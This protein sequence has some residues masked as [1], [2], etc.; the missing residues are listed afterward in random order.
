MDK[1]AIATELLDAL[2]RGAL[3]QPITARDPGFGAE[4]AY[5]VAAEV[6]RRRRSRGEKPVGRKIGFTN[7]TI[8]P[9]YGITMP[10][11]AHVYDS[12]VTFLEGNSGSLAIGRLAQPRIEPEIV[13][14]F[15]TSPGSTR[16]VAQLLSCIDWIAHG[17]E[18][19]QSHFPDWKFKTADTIAA[20]GLHG[21]LVV[22]PKQPVSGLVDLATKLRSFTITVARDGMV[23]ARGG[24]ANV[25]DSPLLAATHFLSVLKDQPQFEP[26]R[27]GEI[28]T[29]GTL[30]APLP[31][32]PG[33]N[34]STDLSGIELEGL[35]LQFR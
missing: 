35:K 20:F 19:V 28:V 11:W 18:V 3:I 31:V 13:L 10:I 27:P 15:K 16:D 1:E 5:D 32:R 34:W 8:W 4:A 25:L 22:G 29:T 7:R 2:D 24:G 26:I 21:A 9:D 33:Q 23:Q 30:T 17:C 12:T 14:H 6:L